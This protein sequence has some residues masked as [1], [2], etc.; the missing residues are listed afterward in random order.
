MAT[1]QKQDSQTIPPHIL[2]HFKAQA[3]SGK[4]LRAY[5]ISTGISPLT[6]YGWRK[7][8]GKHFDAEVKK[9]LNRQTPPSAEAFTTFPTHLLQH[10]TNTAL[11]EIQF[12]D[13]LTFRLYQGATAEWFAPFY[14][15]FRNDDCVC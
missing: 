2:R 14:K 4:T 11:L 1:V 3:K 6:F 13:R 7:R 8:Y 12:N 5:S 15:L 9:K 10:G